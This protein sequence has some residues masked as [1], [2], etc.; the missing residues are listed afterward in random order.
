MNTKVM[1]RIQQCV[2]TSKSPPRTGHRDLGAF[3]RD[4]GLYVPEYLRGGSNLGL[5]EFIKAL[6]S[7]DW[8]NEAERT[9]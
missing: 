7:R 5:E 8:Q 1:S 9:D 3:P 6:K 2:P 4:M